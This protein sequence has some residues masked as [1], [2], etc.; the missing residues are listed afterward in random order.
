MYAAHVFT[1][2]ENSFPSF[3]RPKSKYLGPM[4][5]SHFFCHFFQFLAK[6]LA[7][8]KYQCYD[9]LFSKFSFVLSQKRQ[10]FA[11]FFGENIFKIIT[12]IPALVDNLKCIWNFCPD[13]GDR[14]S[15]LWSQFSAISANFRRKNWRFSQKPMLWSQFFAKTS[16]SLSKKR[17]YFC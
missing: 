9:Q 16:S 3:A 1:T 10:F 6:K 4:L 7:F 13:Q 14:G 11:K 12:S 2:F 17:Q 5:W 15:M 8:F